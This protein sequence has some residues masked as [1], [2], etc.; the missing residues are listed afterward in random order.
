MKT[1]HP[2]VNYG[3]TGVL[4]VNLGTPNSTSWLD[5]RKYLKEF[6]SDRRVIEVNPIIWKIILNLFILT[7]RPGKTAKAYKKIWMTKENMSPLRYFT[8]MQTKKLVDRIGSEKL[9]LDF[10]MRYGDPSI[11][12]KI[13]KLKDAGCENIIVLP[14]YP[15]YAAATTATVCDE[16]YRSLMKMRWQPSLQIVPHYE[17]EQLYIKALVNSLNKKISEISWKPDLIIASYHGI[18][19]KYFDKGDPYQCYCQ[20][21]SRLITEQFNNKIP[22]KT[23]FQSRFGP[24]EWLQPYTDKTFEA[25]PKEGTKN[26][27]VICPGFSSDCV[28]TL[29]EILIQ[30]KESFIDAG[31]KNFDLVPCLND[32]EDHIDLFQHLIKRYLLIK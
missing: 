31:G 26:I 1:D 15:Q 20:K 2:K 17:S 32:N 12:S 6:L 30:G 16:V 9:I 28:E 4:L 11:K 21:T 14:L 3:K 22:I 25:L 13:E 7:F 18:P 10:A 19:K 24:Q 29:E 5:I 27:L 8:I 23:T